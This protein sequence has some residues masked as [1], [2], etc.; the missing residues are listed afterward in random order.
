MKMWNRSFSLFGL[1]ALISSLQI[2]QSAMAAD[3]CIYTNGAITNTAN[4]DTQPDQYT[5]TVYRVG[6]CTSRPGTP[7][8]GRPADLSMCSIVFENSTGSKVTITDGVG[9]ALSGT[10]S[11][12]PNGTYT[13]AYVV[14]AP[15]I[16]IRTQ[17][18]FNRTLQA[19][20]SGSGT[21]TKCWTKDKT[22]YVDGNDYE[23][24][25]ACGDSVAGLGTFTNKL[26]SM[27]GI[28]NYGEEVS[29]TLAVYLTQLD[30][31]LGTGSA[32]NSMGTIAY[33]FGISSLSSS[34]TITNNSSSLD[35]GFK[36]KTACALG[37]TNNNINEI[38]ETAFDIAI[39][40]Y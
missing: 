12:P 17:H 13:H 26:N 30:L 21:G 32:T 6:V 10:F 37:I 7:A 20:S 9:S 35:V 23:S 36:T 18:T 22:V 1:I 2:G 16:Q 38:S 15:Q 39:R 11:R 28:A 33:L 29:N 31:S 3:A 19:F 5:M 4:C 14:I 34:A 24:S 8:T 25:F 40:V 27:G